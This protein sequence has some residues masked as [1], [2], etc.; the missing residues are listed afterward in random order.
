M[1]CSP[2]E[3]VA[4][5]FICCMVTSVSAFFFYFPPPL[6]NGTCSSPQL[7]GCFLDTSGTYCTTR[8]EDKL[9]FDFALWWMTF[10][11]RTQ[12]K[13]TASEHGVQTA[14]ACFLHFGGVLLQC[15]GWKGVLAEVLETLGLTLS[16]EHC[17]RCCNCSHSCTFSS[18]ARSC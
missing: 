16:S 18:P 15:G 17:L 10:N 4:S 9:C 1:Y 6:Q 14:C 7:L 3:A 12:Q 8:L 5:E 11:K 2:P 13:S